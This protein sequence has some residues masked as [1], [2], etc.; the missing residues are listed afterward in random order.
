[1]AIVTTSPDSVRT[2]PQPWQAVVRSAIRDPA[3]LCRRLDLPASLAAQAGVGHRQFR[4]FV[5]ESFLARI[6]PGDPQDPLLLQV[7]PLEQEVNPRPGDMRDP[8]GDAAAQRAPGLIHKYHGRALLIARGV[9]AIHCRYC[10]RRHFPYESAPLTTDQ[11]DEALQIVRNDR[12]LEEIILSGGDPLMMVD[13]KLDEL[14]QLIEAIPHVIRLRIHT[15]LPVVIPSRVTEKLCQLLQHTGMSV[16]MVAHINHPQEIDESVQQAIARLLRHGVLMLNQ[17]VLLR[18]VNDRLETLV[19]LSRH[20]I[21][22]NCLPYYLHQLDRVAGAG[23]FEVP[24]TEGE[25]L[26]RQMREVLPGYAIPRYVREV[27]GESAKQLI[28]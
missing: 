6:R 28:M 23:H 25:S 10:F 2:T 4:T 20:L 8:V 11:F 26:I 21:D 16:I 1:M 9:C 7:L 3:V 5:P 15:R 19:E 18:G 14:I 12:S 22:M 24:Q 13:D 27:A 17:S